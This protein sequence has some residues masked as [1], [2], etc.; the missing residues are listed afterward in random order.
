MIFKM[1][2]LCTAFFLAGSLFM[3]SASGQDVG[4]S[5]APSS[6]GGGGGQETTGGGGAGQGT[7]SAA[8]AVAAPAAPVVLPGAYGSAPITL[9]PGTGRFAKPPYTFTLTLQQGYDDNIYTTSTNHTGSLVNSAQLGFSMQNASPRTIF[10]LDATA[11]I[12]YY[13]N[14]KAQPEDYNDNFSLLI[15]HRFSPRLNVSLTASIGYLSQPNFSAMNATINQQGGNYILG[16]SRLNLSYQWGAKFQ[17]NTS[18]SV[19]ATFYE[20]KSSQSGNITDNT[21]GNEF[22][23]LI[24]PRTSLVAEGRYTATAYPNAPSGDSS[25]V[26]GLLGAD[27]TF[28]SRLSATLRGGFQYRTYTNSTGSGSAMSSVS[29]VQTSPYG[30][31]TMTYLYGHQSTFSWT[32][33]FGLDSS[34]LASQKVTSFRTGVNFNHVVTAKLTVSL[35]LNYNVTETE[36]G[37]RLGAREIIVPFPPGII[38]EHFI[39]PGTT[40]PQ[41]QINCVLGLKYNLT[42]KLSLN[43]SYTFTDVISQPSSG[44]YTRNQFFLGGAY[45]F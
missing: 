35:G 14:R 5:V 21:F 8:P 19:D 22:R 24:N 17:T 41:D 45:T 43:A 32:N 10:T 33:R 4:T 28:T 25:T 13:W 16:S 36:V 42:P 38:I 11:G 40:T 27:Y 12:S 7:S 34:Q 44:S 23:F 31:M 26:Y 15:F 37:N 20:K 1:N 30:E 3:V 29:D 2:R 18:Y 39:V 9:T 6:T